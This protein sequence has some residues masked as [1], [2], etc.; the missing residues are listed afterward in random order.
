[1][2]IGIFSA[3]DGLD[4]RLGFAKLADR[5]HHG[6]HD[7]QVAV[8]G[9]AQECPDLGAEELRM[10]EREADG[11]KPERRVGLVG[12]L[13]DGKHVAAEIQRTDGDGAVLHPLQDPAV[14]AVM[15]L[16]AGELLA[17]QVEELR[18]IQADPLAAVGEDARDLL[19]KL[20]VRLQAD[21]AP[22]ER[23][24]G[25]IAI[26]EQRCVAGFGRHPRRLE[27]LDLLRVGREQHLARRP[28]ERDQ[29]SGTADLARLAC[30]DYAR[31]FQG[32]GEDRRVRRLAP[33]IGDETLDLP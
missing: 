14:G 8:H 33:E 17:V 18:S 27:A 32:P 30:T 7:L 5:R 29:V 23:L 24:R 28:V 12:A 20:D 13:S 11:A 2:P 31:H 1:M 16:L 9:G 22:V 19:W 10:P 26:L 25:P 4:L 21:T 3:T 15:L 6:E